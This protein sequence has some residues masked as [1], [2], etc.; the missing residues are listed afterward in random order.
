MNY[1]LL[2]YV[3]GQCEKKLID[4][5]KEHQCVLPGKIEVFNVTQDVFNDMRIRLIP[6]KSIIVLVFDTDVKLADVLLENIAVLGKQNN[7]IHLYCVPQVRNLEEELVRSTDV[8]APKE[9]L[10][11]KG[12][13]DFKG[14]FIKEKRLYEKLMNHHFDLSK[15]WNTFPPDEYSKMGIK[16]SGSFIKKRK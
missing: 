7:V 15:L 6:P 2:Y 1:R 11:C 5:L 9:I 10:N 13:A 8:K 16:N 14:A 3:E 12:N 4:T